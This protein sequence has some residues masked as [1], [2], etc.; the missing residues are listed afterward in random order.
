[1][2][3]QIAQESRTIEVMGEDIRHGS[4]VSTCNIALVGNPNCGKTTLFN[5][6]T[7]SAQYVGNWP[8]VTVEK[9]MGKARVS[10]QQLNIVDLPGIYSLSAYSLEEVVAR[11]YV[12][13]G[14]VDVIINI[15]DASNIERNLFLSTQLMET[16]LPMV[17]A[18]NMMDVI[19]ARGDQLDL[20][21]LEQSLGIPVVPITASKGIGT[22]LLLQKAFAQNGR[23]TTIPE[24]YPE[25]LAATLTA[26]EQALPSPTANRLLATR[27]YEEGAETLTGPGVADETVARLDTLVVDD[28]VLNEHS[29][30]RDMVISDARYQFI[31]ALVACCVTRVDDQHTLTTSDKID[32]I[33]TNRILAIPIFLVVIFVVFEMAFGPIGTFLTNQFT[34]LLNNIIFAQIAH[35]LRMAGAADWAYNLVV[36]GVLAG[37][38]TVLGFLPQLTIL[39]LMLHI[40]EDSGYMARAAFIMDRLLRRFGLSGKSFIP[41]LM[42]FGCTV[43]ALMAAR[44]LENEKDRR[45]TMMITPFMSCGA[46]LPVYA[47]FAGAFFVANKS[48]VVFSLYLMGIVVA[49]LSGILLKNTVLRGGASNFIMELP[50]YRWPMLKSLVLHT[51]E[52]VKGFLMKAGTILVAASIV[53]WFM[54]TYSFDLHTVTNSADSM[55]GSLGKLIAPVFIPLGFGDWRPT[56]ALI[57]GIVA[58]EAVVDTLGILYG[59]GHAITTGALA[60]PLQHVFTPLSAYAFMTFTLLYMPCMAA[61]S[62][63]KR[64]MGSWRWTLGTVLYQ[65]AVAWIVACL[66]YQ[67]GSLILLFLH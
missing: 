10:G 46:R 60:L 21:Q 48:L 12:T 52:R 56:M 36:N 11:D 5:K 49:I 23:A 42:G 31:S 51:W 59:G 67:V 20:Q 3:T 30:D 9:K 50:P 24:I 26:I 6:L 58:K 4:P 22:D 65:T 44:T 14:D 61:F 34:Y 27:F 15:V 38:G 54:Q 35:W 7:G 29:M 62:T 57:T 32:Q 19:E 53:I 33:V 39:F 66:I 37:V 45:L 28:V 16:G 64:E 43:P 13:S 55:F 1:M 25:K 40:L 8:G 17:I 47:V 41:M 18:L 63:L 2:N